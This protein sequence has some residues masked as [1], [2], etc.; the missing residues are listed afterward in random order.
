MATLTDITNELDS[1]SVSLSYACLPEYCS[2]YIN[3]INSL[4]I[5]H[6]NIRSI[7]KNFNEFRCLLV[8]M[9]IECDMLILSEC[10][11][12]N[13]TTL[14]A[15]A[16]YTS[17]QTYNLKNQND[18][19]V[20]Y[21]KD[22]LAYTITEPPFLDSS[23]L[24]STIDNK[25][26]IIALYRPPSNKS[27][28]NFLD[29][30]NN[31]LSNLTH[32]HSTIV[33]GDININISPDGNDSQSNQ[34]LNL[35][36]SHGLLPAHQLPTRKNNC[37][38]HV[39]LKTNNKAITLVLETTITDHSAVLLNL[40]TSNSKPTQRRTTTSHIN[41]SNA[42]CDIECCDFSNIMKIQDPD[43]ATNELINKLSLIVTRNTIPRTIPCKQRLI[44][45]WITI[46]LLRCIRNRDRMHKK[47]N[48][49]RHNSILKLTYLRYR[50]FCN[51]LLK[52]L[53]TEYEEKEFLK[54][55]NNPKQMWR[56]I[57]NVTDTRQDTLSPT[58]LLKLENS[59]SESVNSIN[60]YFA[61]VG[62]NLASKISLNP[63]PSSPSTSNTFTICNS[64]VLL[65]T[66]EEEVECL[67]ENLRT[68]S[69]PG[70]DGISPKLIKST[71]QILVTPITHIC[72]LALS[73][74][75]FP[76]AL[77]KAIVHPIYKSGDRGSVNNY[78]PI[79][80]LPVISKILERLLYKKLNSFLSKNSIISDNQ[81]GFRRGMS[82]E[83]AVSALLNCI[84]D[85]VD[86]HLKCIG[87][88]IDLSKAFDTVSVPT[89]LN[90][91]EAIGVRG[92]A[93][94]IFESFL[95]DRIQCVK[96]GNYLSNDQPMGFG[97]PQGSLL[98]PLL[99]SIYVNELCNLTHPS[100]RIVTYADDTAII[101]YG[102]NWKVAKEV[103]ETV[104]ERVAIW[105]A[106]NSL[107]LNVD[108]TKFI[109]FG[110]RISALPP[111]LSLVIK[112]HACAKVPNCQCQCPTVAR[113]SVIKYLGLQLDACLSWKNHLQSVSA[114]I[115][116]LIF[117]FKKLR[118]SAHSKILK[119]V[120]TALCES[121]LCYC[122]TAWGGAAKT[123]F[124]E[125]ER[126]QRAVIK[127]LLGK[128]FRYPTRQLY[129]DYKVPTVR[130]LF[131]LR[132][133][134]RKH[135]TLPPQITISPAQRR[136][137]KPVCP[138]IYTNTT[139]AQRHYSYLS[140]LLYNKLNLKLNLHTLNTHNCKHKLKKYLLTAD[141]NDTEE[142]V[143]PN[144]T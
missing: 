7:N 14:P 122:I 113:T 25:V 67:I 89:L 8:T 116:K 31:V 33:I 96:L 81:F 68:D 36:A 102:H 74:G 12:K 107:T 62:K 9:K 28:E 118:L 35:A 88:F 59:P 47:A 45:P 73:T 27:A 48:K 97:V 17:H 126:A 26:A 108:K 61:Q 105:L 43:Q 53:K 69:A 19:L 70:W 24:V 120:Y 22:H 95:S 16:G 51:N 87:I 5:L 143:K 80:V 141:Y 1:V 2:S 23:C 133:I 38:D 109:T 78:R 71:R 106:K 104:L 128:P 75:I 114:R 40:E 37:L 77:K 58:N 83:D 130:Q 90:K 93:Y 50:N 136:R 101:T 129:L 79:S 139:F 119:M 110:P 132:T 44:K 66:D 54:A 20:I 92:I 63:N 125:V 91:L 137:P 112:V 115:R 86:K 142:L 100:T 65:E 11:L 4:N 72:N 82:T 85:R 39:L 41:L 15:L 99:F 52:K 144:I 94:R 18:G 84:V 42:I 57:R 49:E 6:L 138:K 135:K 103:A 98:S 131:I 117:V 140:A 46:G 60:T 64:M 13:C 127:V 32:C 56:A 34:Y 55:K 3:S 10:W 21:I 30:L 123:T 76:K 124:I 111:E 121:I 134:M 29:S